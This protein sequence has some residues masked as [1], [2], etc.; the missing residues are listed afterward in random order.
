MNI[1]KALIRYVR[2]IDKKLIKG[3]DSLMVLIPKQMLDFFNLNRE[4]RSIR[5]RL[6]K[7]G[8]VIEPR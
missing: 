5:V 6:S 4:N 3:K 1:S 2:G 8:I 7:E